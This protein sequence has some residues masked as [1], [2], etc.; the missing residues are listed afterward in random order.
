MNLNKLDQD[1]NAFSVAPNLDG[2][3]QNFDIKHDAEHEETMDLAEDAVQFWKRQLISGIPRITMPVDFPRSSVGASKTAHVS[4]VI[5]YPLSETLRQ[6]NER[7]GTNTYST[8]LTV[9]NVLLYRYTGQTEMLIGLPAIEYRVDEEGDINDTHHN[10][11]VFHIQFQDDINFIELLTK[12]NEVTSEYARHPDVSY[13]LLQEA[14]GNQAESMQGSLYNLIYS[15]RNTLIGSKEIEDWTANVSI[16]ENARHGIDLA[17]YVEDTGNQVNITL[18]YNSEL[19]EAETIQR[20]AKH[21]EALLEA[22]TLNPS[23]AIAT[24]PML[25]EAEFQQLTSGWNTSHV[26]YPAD[27]C[28]HWLFEQQAAEAPQAKA[29][30]FEN[31]HLTY[32]ELNRRA[33]QV[34]HYLIEKGV[35][36][37]IFVPLCMHPSIE[38]FVAILGIL[39]AGGAYVPVDPDYPTDR[40]AYLL[41]DTNATLVLCNHKSKA[42][43]AEFKAVDLLVLDDDELKLES[44]PTNNLTDVVVNSNDLAYV[45]YTSGTTGR[46]KGVMIEHRALIDH[47]YGV[48]ES[49]GLKSCKSFALFSPL[50]FD[51]GHSI[52]HSCFSMGTCLHV[53]PKSLIM[54]SERVV[55]YLNDNEID[56][57]KIVPSLW[58]S[59]AGLQK[60]ALAKKVMIF[61][62]EAFALGI[63][64]HLRNVNYR[65]A[66]YNHYG[67]TEVTIGKTIHR[68]NLNADYQTV[69]I[70]KP[71]SNTQVY[72][73]D[74]SLQPVPVGITG[75][76]YI[77]GNGLA[78]GYLNR[79]DLTAEKF[80]VNPFAYLPTDRMYKTGDKVRWLSDGNIEYLG[81][82]DE[83]IKI[84]GHRIEPGEIEGVL[85]QS[86]MVSHA[87]VLALPCSKG[88][89]CLVQY[90]VPNSSYNKDNL[91]QFLKQKL[92]A[93]MVPC[94]GIELENL[95]LT[96]HGKIDKKQLAGLAD[97]SRK[98][99]APVTSTEIKL[100]EIWESVLNTGKIG[101]HDNFFEIG[102]NSLLAAMIFV[103]I[104]D[105]FR[106]NFP[107]SA[108]FTAPT[109]HL[110]ATV[111]DEPV[112]AFSG[113][114]SLI[115]I[116]P[117]GNK[118]PLFCVHAGHGHVL[119]YGNLALHLDSDQPVYGIQAKGI[120]GTD[121]PFNNMEAIAAYY[122][123]EIRKVQPEGPYY[124]AGYCLG[125]MIT[126]EMAQQLQQQ[127][128]E[129]ALLAN[130]N[131]ISPYYRRPAPAS[132]TNEN[133]PQPSRLDKISRHLNNIKELNWKGKF[134]Y[135]AKRFWVQAKSKLMGPVFVVNYKVSGALFKLYLNTKHKAPDV[136]ARK[137]TGNSL[138]IL[139]CSYRPKTYNG[140]MVVFRSPDIYTVPH[141]GWKTLITNGIKAISIPGEHESRRDILNEPYVQHLAKELERFLPA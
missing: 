1:I 44:Y 49:A 68:V 9:Y 98:F 23:A 8:L 39:K 104:K 105:T 79:P 28:I 111:L 53:L 21:F 36:P 4:F 135:I 43:L 91:S 31:E 30:V 33:N 37:G 124:L 130:F 69:P 81:R 73:L 75:E 22:A 101:I 87:V 133:K 48:I 3:S 11:K 58:L 85:L 72:I 119:F 19:F 141:L 118:T 127:G 29:L 17:L 65:G 45:I 90:I 47:C 89:S 66:V 94:T 77:A 114:K 116:Q 35:K 56:G 132:V 121:L 109:I 140:K 5:S 54:D 83:Q 136:L 106:R 137:Y 92:P 103:K 12:V 10:T 55:A 122:I 38:M 40:V 2:L 112:K 131:G 102:G 108:I 84:D 24:L 62:G 61:G 95:P 27:K 71:F 129:V 6:M 15:Y 113:S 14:L 50:V 34:A 88:N 99:A 117:H 13:E 82:V 67:P 59:Y 25:S 26:N 32:A 97:F 100:A 7:L 41:E 93:Y 110:L 139:Q 42:A 138:Y 63:L 86:G 60:I 64:N 96:R 123:E 76:L 78:R 80:I 134:D 70:G 107:L 52:I 126:F 51:A 46:P 57:I 18:T 120:D 128:Q 20:F 16:P 115:P 74:D 125:A